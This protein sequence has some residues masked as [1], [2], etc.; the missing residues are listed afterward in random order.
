MTIKKEFG[1]FQTPDNLAAKVVSLVSDLF[2]LPDIVIE[3]TAGYGAF[4]KASSNLW[5]NHPQYVGY[6]INH[7]YA[8]QASLSLKDRNIIVHQRDFFTEDWKSNLNQSGLSRVLVIG[9]PPWVTNSALGQLGSSNLPHKANFQGLRGFDAR[10]GKSNFDIAEWMLIRLVESLPPGGALA[11]L[12]K[13]MTA[14][15][16]LKHLWKTEGG[17]DKSLLFRIDAKLS[18]DVSVDACLFFITGRPTNSRVATIFTDIDINST[19]TQFGLVDGDLVSDINAYNQFKKLDGGSSAYTWRSGIKHDMTDVM[20]FTREGDCYQNGR[21]ELVHLEETFIYP[22]LKSSDLANG[23][24]DV[25]KYVLVTQKSTGDDT[26]NISH[27]APLTWRYLMANAEALKS[28]RSSIYHKRPQFSVFGIGPYSFAPWKVAVSGLYKTLKFIVVPPID[29]RPV[30]IDDTCYSIACN[31]E[32][33]ARLLCELLSSQPAQAFLRSLIFMD[34]KR[35]VTVDVL[36]RL[37]IIEVARS[38]GRLDEL[39]D[40]IQSSDQEREVDHQMF[41]LME[42]SQEYRT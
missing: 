37:S 4:L 25:R 40:L 12:C 17:R 29:D 22:L 8:A 7:E 36:R 11:M 30:M 21:G 2:G 16:V 24:F 15:K 31:F 3:P 23:R 35:P 34:S 9:N 33:E 10:T 13:T 20:E 5:G 27:I 41:L 42:Q 32:A 6:E 28:R 14:R 18:F 1:D 26:A 38:L 39:K 19:S